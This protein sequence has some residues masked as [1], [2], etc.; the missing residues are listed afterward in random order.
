MAGARPLD[1]IALYSGCTDAY[2]T[3]TAAQSPQK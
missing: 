2:K 1:E 3:D